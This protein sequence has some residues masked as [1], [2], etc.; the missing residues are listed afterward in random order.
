MTPKGRNAMRDGS[1]PLATLAARLKA[2]TAGDKPSPRSKW[3]LWNLVALIVLMGIAGL[4]STDTS[5][6]TSIR[7]S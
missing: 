7:R 6:S 1:G 4:F 3:F 5:G 2:R